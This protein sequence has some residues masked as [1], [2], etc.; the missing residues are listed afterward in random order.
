MKIDEA[1]ILLGG[2]G[3]RLLPLTK[4][5][6]KEMLPIY[7]VPTIFLLVEEAYK[8]GIKKII[9]V[10][11]RHNRKLIESFFSKDAYYDN[12]LK[13][14]PDKQKLLER[15]NNI[16]C[17]MEFKYVYQNMKGTF[18]ALYSARKFIKNN[19]F[20]LMYGDD[21]ID[22]NPLVTKLLIN[23][24]RKD[25]K[26]Y[27]AIRK[28]NDE[29]LPDVGIVKLDKDNNII[30]LVPKKNH[31]SK[32]VIHGRMLLNKKIFDAK[33]KLYKHDNDEYYLSYAL[34]HFP[35]EV[36]GIKYTGEY[37]NIGE[38]T[39]YIKASIHFALKDKNERNELIKYIR[40]VK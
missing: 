10:V 36:K 20:I 31:N 34:L 24:F 15:I 37:F 26:M 30:D 33:N 25:N 32:C 21:L 13:D 39:G 8:S 29:D 40:E 11:T 16:T 1:V 23:E 7:D 5:V 4:T 22:S 3:T 9:F 6:S 35:N 17:N 12:F 28:E 14:K 19:N 38:K 27:V 2:M 18:G